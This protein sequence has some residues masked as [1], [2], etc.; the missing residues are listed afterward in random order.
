[1]QNG[2]GGGFGRFRVLKSKRDWVMCPIPCRSDEACVFYVAR[3]VPGR[4][5]VSARGLVTDYVLK[6][7]P[8]NARKML[9]FFN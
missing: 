8:S 5:G 1:L 9:E 4:L 7:N 2:G 6:F 3:R